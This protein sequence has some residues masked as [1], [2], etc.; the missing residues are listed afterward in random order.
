[1]NQRIIPCLHIRHG[2]VVK[3]KKFKDIQDVADPVSLA[4]RYE[5]EQADEL[6]ILDITGRDRVQF[7]NII[8]E[9]STTLSIPLAVG[10]G[11][12][13]LEDVAAVQYAGAHKVSITIAAIEYTNVLHAFTEK[14]VCEKVIL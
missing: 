4:K 7:L 8:K 13:T 9:I 6:F 2:R 14:F 11:I 3:G 10:G 12:R 1:I 5:R